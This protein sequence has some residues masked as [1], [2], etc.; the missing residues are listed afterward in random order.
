M[1]KL[2]RTDIIK[3]RHMYLMQCDCGKEE[4]KRPD[5]V[6]SGRTTMCKKCSAK[7]TALHYPPPVNKTGYE[8]LSGTHFS[9]IKSTA[10]RRK[11]EFKVTEKELWD[12][13]EAQNKKCA[14]TDVDIV[15]TPRI[16]KNNPDWSVITASLD[17]KDNNLGYTIDNVWWVHKEINR[18]KNNYSLVE[19]LKWSRLL[20]NKHGNPDP[21]LGGDILEGAT[22]RDRVSRDS[23]IPTSAQHPSMDDDIV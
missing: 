10:L 8:G 21:S 23:N 7:K 4:Y 11:L 19:L 15:L 6:Q 20:L 18:L 13:Y 5:H 1:L 14:L 17:R 22:T 16:Y 2:I 9:H 3:G 12:L